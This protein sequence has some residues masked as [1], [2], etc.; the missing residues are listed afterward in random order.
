MSTEEKAQDA[1]PTG[2]VAD[3]DF[4][5]AKPVVPD[6]PGVHSLVGDDG[7]TYGKMEIKAVGDEGLP[8]RQALL[9]KGAEQAKAT[10]D[11]AVARGDDFIVMAANSADDNNTIVTGAFH[12]FTAVA[13]IDMFLG[14][15]GPLLGAIT[16]SKGPS[17]S[18]GTPAS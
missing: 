9:A 13:M 17:S 18:G 4:F 14:S 16:K 10:I 3:T 1:A 7:E 11:A 12:P 15:I 6:A 8:D 2:V 5:S